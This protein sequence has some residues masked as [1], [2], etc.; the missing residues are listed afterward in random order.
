VANDGN[1]VSCI[2][3]VQ[4]PPSLPPSLLFL[5]VWLLFPS[6]LCLFSLSHIC[7]LRIRRVCVIAV[8]A[9]IECV[10]EVFNQ[11]ESPTEG[12]RRLSTRSRLR[13]GAL[14]SKRVACRFNPTTTTITTSDHD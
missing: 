13:H 9:A 5:S 7:I 3:L 4:F 11:N 14:D 12:P 8:A 1:Y 10:E 6:L 2:I